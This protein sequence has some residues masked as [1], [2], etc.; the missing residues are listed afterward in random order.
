MQ[1]YSAKY[2]I[3]VDKM[4]NKGILFSLKVGDNVL[5][6]NTLAD[7]QHGDAVN[8]LLVII[9]EKSGLFRIATREES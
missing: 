4:I 5:V 1:D 9:K 3:Q 8:L 6:A 7:R 2:R